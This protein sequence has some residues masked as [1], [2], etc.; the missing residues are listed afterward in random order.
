MVT[1]GTSPTW[2]HMGQSASGWHP[3]QS[4]K[5]HECASQCL[6]GSICDLQHAVAN[7]H[8][9]IEVVLCDMIPDLLTPQ[10][11]ISGFFIGSFSSPSPLLGLRDVAHVGHVI[12]VSV[13]QRERADWHL[14]QT[15]HDVECGYDLS[16]SPSF[17]SHDS[18]VPKTVG[19]AVT[20]NRLSQATSLS[21]ISSG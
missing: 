4:K 16:S 17:L 2:T 11:T 15:G 5:A 12:N 18:G 1:C 8:G 19:P 14:G 3:P 6:H 9:L 21:N 10:S 7:V 20:D 13:E